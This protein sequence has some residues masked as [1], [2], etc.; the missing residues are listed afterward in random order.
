MTD[1]LQATIGDLK[2]CGMAQRQ[3]AA[4]LHENNDFSHYL[5]DLIHL[6]NY[7]TMTD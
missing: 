1:A 7:L 4:L 2:Q 3:L 6:S 5:A